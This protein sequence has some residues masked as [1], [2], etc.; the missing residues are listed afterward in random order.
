MSEKNFE[1]KN[2]LEKNEGGVRPL[3]TLSAEQK[4]VKTEIDLLKNKYKMIRNNP[5][6][7]A[8]P[9]LEKTAREI[10]GRIRSLAKENGLNEKELIAELNDMTPEDMEQRGHAELDKLESERIKHQLMVT[11]GDPASRAKYYEFKD[12]AR[13]IIEKYGLDASHL[14]RFEVPELPPEVAAQLAEMPENE[15][16]K[17]QKELAA[18]ETPS[19]KRGFFK[20]L[21]GIGSK[22]D[23]QA[24][25]EKAE[26]DQTLEA[27][28]K[29]IQRY[30]ELVLLIQEAGPAS[31]M[32][33]ELA[34]VLKNVKKGAGEAI[35]RL[36]PEDRT[37]ENLGPFSRLASNSENTKT[38]EL[39]ESLM[40][41]MKGKM[42]KYLQ[43][44]MFTLSALQ[45][46]AEAIAQ[47][48][49]VTPN[50]NAIKLEA[51]AQETLNQTYAR[52][53]EKAFEQAAADSMVT[54]ITLGS[55]KETQ[56]KHKGNQIIET[57]RKG[58]TIRISQE[59]D[60]KLKELDRQDSLAALREVRDTAR[61]EF[62]PE[63][64]TRTDAPVFA[65]LPTAPVSPGQTP[66]NPTIVTEAPAQGIESNAPWQKLGVRTPEK[67]TQGRIRVAME[68]ENGNATTAEEYLSRP[69]IKI[70]PMPEKKAPERKTP[71]IIKERK[72]AKKQATAP[73]EK[74]ETAPNWE[75]MSIFENPDSLKAVKTPDQ[76][77]EQKNYAYISSM[78][79]K[80][81]WYDANSYKPV[82]KE[83]K[84]IYQLDKIA[85]PTAMAADIVTA[86]EPVT[87]KNAYFSQSIF[88]TKNTMGEGTSLFVDIGTTTLNWA[89]KNEKNFGKFVRG[90]THEWIH[91]F[92]RITLGMKNH[93][94]KEAV[95]HYFTAF[96][97][98][99]SAWA[100]EQYG[101][102][103]TD[104]VFP[105]GD[106]GDKFIESL[107]FEDEYS[108]LPAEL[109]SKYKKMHA[110]MTTI[111]T[112]LKDT[113]LGIKIIEAYKK[114]AEKNPN[115]EARNLLAQ[116]EKN[117]S[118]P[119]AR[120]T[121]AKN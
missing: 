13:D 27:I 7:Y 113:P 38:A 95:A 62:K 25:K 31:T 101:K 40:E 19:E 8:R 37:P 98:E 107:R 41:K 72:G 57:E 11:V 48:G 86:A 60:K 33:G 45:G 84:R 10:E 105:E 81:D 24:K 61:A 115:G 9:Y 102:E 55:K 99:F 47:N 50:G 67:E 87:A 54:Q 12:R 90:I 65:P 112:S 69:E 53:G 116:F 52:L 108:R 18:A 103:T 114:D 56:P 97:N 120:Y 32:A 82:M 64:Q 5:D 91:A 20:K 42:R 16:T 77:L 75:T 92:E 94:E 104:A 36:K 80:V 30:E 34:T 23:K 78:L 83:I 111:I 44:A 4:Q 74:I 59:D 35:R 117:T 68:D 28:G 109:Q 39:K 26:R 76:G 119:T 79:N 15:A 118:A 70:T 85:S 66:N 14:G 63:N 58:H 3:E 17:V 51:P 43:V 73:E 29:Y 89:G 21:F 1:T 100:K 121:I 22:E 106:T 2:T 71:R 96:P 46:P 93:E 110:R 88:E 49:I 6:P